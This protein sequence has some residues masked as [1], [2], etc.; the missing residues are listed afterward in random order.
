MTS[1]PGILTLTSG[2]ALAFRLQ[3]H[4]LAQRLPAEAL[5]DA[6]AACGIQNSPP[7]SAAIS[8]HARIAGFTPSGLQ[9]ALAVEKSLLQVWCM[10]SAPHLIPTRDLAIFT[11]GLLAQDEDALRFFM[12]GSLAHLE[13]FGLSASQI[14]SWTA[15][16]L[17]GVLHG[18][19]PTKDELGRELARRV[20]AYLPEEML[21]LW[22]APDGMRQ[23]TY[24]ES[25]VRFALNAV[26]LQGAFCLPPLA[27]RAASFILTDEWLGSL[28]AVLSVEQARR[29]LVRRYL[30]CYGPSTPA[31]FAAWAGIAPQQATASWELARPE[32]VQ[33]SFDGRRAWLL[34]ADLEQI[35][36]AQ[37]AQGIRLLPPHDPLLS[38]R[39]RA[40]LIADRS[41]HASIWRLAG[42]PGVI[43]ADGR[44]VGT[45]R[46][47][48]VGKRLKIAVE[49]FEPSGAGMQ[50]GIEVE[51]MALARLQGCEAVEVG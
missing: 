33:V 5:L 32:L 7:G 26:A 2:Q 12:R 10:R 41:L 35:E 11:T 24:G 37:P 49:R 14:V 31:H 16:T 17:P 13:R 39:D 20:L 22:T 51:A 18:R 38:L 1:L 15:A 28:P 42:S 4:H 46:S 34:Q 8:L 47:H 27:G 48:K 29:G 40:T 44:V 43:L 21:D 19:S 45:W 30:H 9:Q 36:T 50:T 25:L 3:N 6:A 23:N